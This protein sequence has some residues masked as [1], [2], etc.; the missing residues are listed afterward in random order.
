MKTLGGVGA[1][2][3]GGMLLLTVR[4]GPAPPSPTAGNPANPGVDPLAAVAAV[5]DAP[6]RS[7]PAAVA[8]VRE[9][10]WCVVEAEGTEGIRMKQK[11]EKRKVKATTA[12]VFDWTWTVNLPASVCL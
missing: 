1:V 3:F 4:I 6:P 12:E 9:S 11:V 10:R 7:T 8:P 5:P 2:I